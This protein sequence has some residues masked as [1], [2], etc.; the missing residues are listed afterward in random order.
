MESITV[1]DA[2]VAPPTVAVQPVAKLVPE[3][4]RLPPDVDRA[5]GA[6]LAT[7]GVDP[8]TTYTAFTV[9]PEDDDVPHVTTTA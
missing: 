5:T 8:D 6:T 3:T 1:T 4:V 9:A 7:V 2:Q